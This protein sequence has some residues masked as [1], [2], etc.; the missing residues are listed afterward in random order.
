[1]WESGGPAR[2]VRGRGEPAL[3]VG[4]VDESTSKRHRPQ[5]QTVVAPQSTE[6]W[7]VPTPH[8]ALTC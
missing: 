7:V 6:P 1:M 5:A 2:P 3:P 4:E 8:D